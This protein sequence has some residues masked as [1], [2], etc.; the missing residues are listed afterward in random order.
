[1]HNLMLRFYL[2]CLVMFMIVSFMACGPQTETVHTPEGATLP[3]TFESAGVYTSLLLM[4][5]RIAETKLASQMCR[6]EINRIFGLEC[7]PN[8]TDGGK[9]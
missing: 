7:H 2:S 6:C 3:R 5:P 9:G 8:P 4:C 1:M